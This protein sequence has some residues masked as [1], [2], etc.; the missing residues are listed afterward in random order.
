MADRQRRLLC[1]HELG[2]WTMG[3]V[4]SSHA[5][6]NEFSFTTGIIG[7]VS[8]AFTLGTFIRV[9]VYEQLRYDLSVS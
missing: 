3:V 8:F 5:T 2:A 1:A 7:V 9:S 6:L 4:V